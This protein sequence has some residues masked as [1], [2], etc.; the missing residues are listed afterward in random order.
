MFVHAQQ[1]SPHVGDARE[2][3]GTYGTRMRPFARVRLRMSTCV[4]H[5][6]ESFATLG[7]LEW[8]LVGV[9][10]TMTCESLVQM[11]A[12][13][14]NVAHE[15]T[16]VLVHN[17]VVLPQVSILFERLLAQFAFERAR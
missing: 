17:L 2:W 7:T 15:S 8:L 12:F 4:T 9:Q 3:F 14:A 1:V 10:A 5:L 6:T 11:K 13:L 16:R